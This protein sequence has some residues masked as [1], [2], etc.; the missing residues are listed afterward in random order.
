MIEIKVSVLHLKPGMYVSNLDRPWTDTPFLFQGLLIN[1]DD[2]IEELRKHCEFVYI[3]EERGESADVYMTDDEKSREGIKVEDEL[4]KAKETHKR[5]Q[6][7]FNKLAELI[8]NSRPLD[9][10]NISNEVNS[11]VEG[12]VR[13]SDAYVLLTKLKRK[14][15]YTYGHC[16]SSSIFSILMGKQLGL[17]K[18][19]LE[20][21]AIGHL[22]FDIGKLRLPERILKKGS[23]LSETEQILARKHVEYS[24][25]ILS[26][27]KGINPSTI[28]IA[29]YHHERYDGNGYPLGLSG[30]QIPLYARIAAIIDAYDAMTS[31][32][33]YSAQQSHDKVIKELYG[34]KNIDF[35]GDLLETFIQ[36]LGT[37][38]TGSLIELNTGEVGIVLQQNKISRLRPR[39]MI[40]L[41]RK[42]EFNDYFPIINLLTKEEDKKEGKTIEISKMLEAGAYGIDPAEFYL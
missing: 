5:L 1:G 35:Q 23:S 21:I 15:N 19:E 38:P 42:K 32:R 34:R 29:R 39:V 12:S 41:N 18:D 37:Y 6:N 28:D 24:T 22:L 36:S 11:L 33:P 14:D 7:E 27:T 31:S 10:S 13:S 2:D 25:K 26:E 8:K 3:D 30:N 9:I 17:K 16:L 40:V 4:P 20:E